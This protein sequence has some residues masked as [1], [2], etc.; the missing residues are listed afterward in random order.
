MAPKKQERSDA[1]KLPPLW[2]RLQGQIDWYDRKASANQHA[3][4]ASKIAIIVCTV[5]IPIV[6]E[7]SP[8]AVGTAAGVILL[9]EGLQQVNKWQENWILYRST[10]EGLRNEQHHYNEKSGSYAKLT[11]EEAHRVAGR[12]RRRAGLSRALQ[13]DHRPSGEGGDACGDYA[14]APVC[15]TPTGWLLWRL[16][17]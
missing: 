10:C 15:P 11:P 1:P 16:P 13:M 5:I 3:Y 17:A 14:H 4:K 9:L 8:L 6:A 7:Y 12:A 2:E